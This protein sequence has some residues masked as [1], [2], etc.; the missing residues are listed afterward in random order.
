MTDSLLHRMQ[1]PFWLLVGIIILLPA[2]NS[3]LLIF[4]TS[5]E[6]FFGLLAVS[7]ATGL[8][9]ACFYIIVG[10]SHNTNVHLNQSNVCI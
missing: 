10:K 5:R 3:I 9:V 2:I 6:L 7:L 8:L 4:V 1:I